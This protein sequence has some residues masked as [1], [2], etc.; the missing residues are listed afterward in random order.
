MT[1][2]CGLCDHNICVCE[3]LPEPDPDQD[4]IDRERDQRARVYWAELLALRD[5]DSTIGDPLQARAA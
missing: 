3:P 1:R 4:R 5:A 2:P